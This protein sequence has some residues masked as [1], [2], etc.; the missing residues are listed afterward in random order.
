MNIENLIA[1]VKLSELTD[2]QLLEYYADFVK[3]GHYEAVDE[4]RWM[5]EL[6]FGMR[7]VKDEIL[8]R[9][10]GPNPAEDW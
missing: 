10:S 6:P 9:M 4:F 8:L 3:W 5:R 7:D 1:D 2:E